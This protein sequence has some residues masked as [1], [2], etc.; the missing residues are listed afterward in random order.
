M[1]SI[2]DGLRRVREIAAQ[3]DWLAILVTTGPSGE[4]TVS[5]VNVG[6]V[7]HPVTGETTLALV[8]RGN[9][10]KLRNL[11]FEPSA[12]LVFRSGW[13]WI[14]ARGSTEI[15]GPDDPLPGLPAE[16]LPGLLRDIYA[17]AGGKHSDLDEYDR[18]M[19]ADRRAA[20]FVRPKRFSTNPAPHDRE[21]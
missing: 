17:A 3:E 13:D 10:A 9:T 20:V 5:L 14:A 18:E 11:R 19:V 6:V 12:T 1:M 16:R 4:P 2:D 15:A 7:R 8:S 21:D